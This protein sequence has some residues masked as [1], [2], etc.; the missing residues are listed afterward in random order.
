MI[1]QALT[2]AYDRHAAAPDP[3][4]PPFGYSVENISFALELT[5]DGTPIRLLDRR[6]KIKNKY[7]P[8]GMA[9]PMT[10]RTSGVKPKFLWDN[11]SYVF[12]LPSKKESKKSEEEKQARTDKEHAAFKD[13]HCRLIGDTED[14]GLLA[15]L[16]FLKTWQPLQ[17]T[18]LPGSDYVIDFKNS[19][20]VFRL[21]SERGFIHQ[22]LA[23][24]E[25]WQAKLRSQRG[26][27]GLCLVTGLG[28][29][30]I[31]ELHPSVGGVEDAQ[32]SGAYLV[33][34]NIDAFTSYGKKSGHNS[35]V[36]EDS[37]FAYTA[38]LNHLLTANNGRE[39]N[40]RLKKTNAVQ[41]ADA[42]TVFW[43]E[44]QDLSEA[45]RAEYAAHQLFAPDDTSETAKLKAVFDVI[46]EG[47]PLRDAGLDEDMTFYILGLSPNAA[48]LSVRFWHVSTLGHLY[49][50]F[51]QHWD[52]LRIDCIKWNR[53]PALWQIV[54]RTAPARKNEKGVVKYDS[55]HVPPN[56]VGELMRAILTLGRYPGSLLT[57][58]VMRVRTDG[59]LDRIRVALIKATIV[60]AMRLDKRLPKEDYLMRTDPDDPNPARRLGRL[61]AVLERA[62]LA[63]LGDKINATIKDKYLGA[64]AATPAQ[65]FVGLIKNSQHH[66]KR[67]RNGHADAQWIKDAKHARNVGFGIERDIGRLWG[68][69]DEGLPV[70]H[71]IEEQGLFFVGYYQERF[72]GKPD[73]HVGEEPGVDQDISGDQE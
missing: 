43:A 2:R 34:Y 50:A 23:A 63:A 8:D 27:P 46:A 14:E 67:L 66:T 38:V 35:P 57:N 1:L 4:V 29:T 71:S 13:L 25:I 30:P 47:R 16:A 17:W 64:A 56:L 19:N 26:A 9:V 20:L 40:G 69:F 44:A 36:G 39:H 42:T 53:P 54:Q 22:R 31:A 70:Q 32:T 12:G 62:Q 51:R 48:R 60:R 72:G 55:K 68:A 49:A 15:L 7:Y 18:S 59:V 73:Q 33:S 5:R 45:E 37:A 52:D 10:E 41:I 28:D 11:A 6:T 61:F 65:V 3:K 21:E 24:Q 58:L